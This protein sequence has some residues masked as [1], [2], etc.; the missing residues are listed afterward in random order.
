MT[1]TG[2]AA[3]PPLRIHLDADPALHAQAAWA[4]EALLARSGVRSW[5]LVDDEE[6]ADL[7]WGTGGAAI[8][9]DP[10]TWEFR[11]D[12]VPDAARDPLAATFWWL[13][14]E[15]ERL[16]PPGAF[17]E[18]GRFRYTASAVAR[19]GDP[20]ATPVDVLAE[21]LA[22]EL[23]EPWCLAD[24]WDEHEPAYRLVLTHD[25]DLPRRW[26]KTGR[27]RALRAVRDDA[28][29][30]RLLR[31]ARTLL[32]LAGAHFRRDPWTNADRIYRLESR[33]G[34]RSTCY[35]LAGQ[36]APEDGDAAEHLEAYAYDVPQP[37]IGLHGSYTA[38]VTRGRIAAERTALQQRTGAEALDH[39]F[40]YLRHRTV[41]AWPELAAAGIRSDASLG[42][43][44]QPGFR[45]G[46]AHPFRA[47]DHAA[48]AP[49]DLV[50]IPLAV[51]DA[52]F[53]ERYLD[54]PG[55]DERRR[56][57]LEAVDTIRAV[58]GAASLLVHN[59]R[60]C[61]AGDEGWTRTYRNVLRHVAATGGAG[62]SAGEAAD[63]YRARLPR[64]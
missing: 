17:D 8:A 55:R 34:A 60:L 30:G 31:A 21:A 37:G 28:R 15:E 51:M 45:A 9:H 22:A 58:G 35:L 52:S 29:R 12:E 48:G 41:Q 43:A 7:A 19:L 27:R 57:I 38:S 49:L 53:D 39:R 64:A 40:H 4:L 62:V 14:R 2:A 63:A 44:E 3:V 54:V 47:W 50:I 36:H 42:F 1:G 59:D 6:D 16:A 13:A 61:C 10:A 46:T 33:E 25:I 24:P 32:A 23:P 20:L 11:W 26:T 56:R 18:H 5:E